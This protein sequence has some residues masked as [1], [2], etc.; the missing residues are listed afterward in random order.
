MTIKEA[1]ELLRTVIPARERT[2][3][4]EVQLM[5]YDHYELDDP[6]RCRIEFRVWDGRDGHYGLSLEIAVQKAML[7]NTSGRGVIGEADSFADEAEVL[8]SVNGYRS[9]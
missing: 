3:G 4:I 8:I 1:L 9:N 2:V 7:A 5:D 6:N